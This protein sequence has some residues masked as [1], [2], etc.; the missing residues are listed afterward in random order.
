MRTTTTHFSILPSLIQLSFHKARIVCSLLGDCLSHFFLYRFWFSH[1]LPLQVGSCVMCVWCVWCVCVW[2]MCMMCVACVCGM[3]LLTYLHVVNENLLRH[4]NLEKI[5]RA[6]TLGIYPGFQ[7]QFGLLRM[8]PWISKDEAFPPLLPSF[9]SGGGNA[10]SK[11]RKRCIRAV[12][13]IFSEM[14]SEN[15]G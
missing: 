5:K 4:I 6:W 11:G 7:A 3:Y 10:T 12:G 1:F 14:K 9:F 2:R 15:F 8:F 13:K